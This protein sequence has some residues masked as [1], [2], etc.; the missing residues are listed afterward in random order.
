MLIRP[1]LFL[2]GG[3]NYRESRWFTTWSKRRWVSRA[4]LT[5]VLNNPSAWCGALLLMPPLPI[6]RVVEEYYLPEILR[7]AT[8]QRKVP[9]GDGVLEA[10]DTSIGS[11]ICE[12]LWTPDRW[13]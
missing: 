3:G 6:S 9:F 5:P 1:K 13:E 2:A 7:K 8:G 10:H 12:E 4:R 11:E